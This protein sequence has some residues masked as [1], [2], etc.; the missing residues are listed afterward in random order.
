VDRDGASALFGGRDCAPFDGARAPTRPEIDDN[1][2][3]EDCNGSD[4]KSASLTAYAAGEPFSGALTPDRVEPYNLV[5]VVIEAARADHLDAFGYGKSTMP[6]F[7]HLAKESWLFSRAFSQSTATVLSVPSMMTG[8][9]PAAMHWERRGEHPQPAKSELLLAE[10]LQRRDYRTGFIVSSYIKKSFTGLQRGFQDLPL[11]EPDRQRKK[12]GQ[13]RDLYVTAQAAQFLA[14]MGADDHFFLVV[15]FPDP[16]APYIRHKDIDSARFGRGQIGNYDTELAFT[17]EQLRAL[18][19]ML[20]SRKSIWAH[21]ILVVTADHGEEFHEHGAERHANNCH[22]ETTHVPLLVRIPG[23]E[24]QRIDAPVGLVDILPTFLELI[25]E[26]EDLGRLT[27]RSLLWPALQP[28]ETDGER[29]LFCS[30]ASVTDKYGTF[31][32]RSLRQGNWAL[33]EDVNEGRF[34]LFDTTADPAEKNDL[35]AEAEHAELVQSL[36]ARLEQSL[37]GN[38]RDHTQM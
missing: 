4:G 8:T 5:W 25:G 37:V 7:S 27:G 32:R 21:T 10:R 31:F 13:R 23:M 19:E 26:N 22:V 12:D 20:R 35:A 29:P 16:H 18:V 3:D 36:R 9:D 38:L 14:R 6:Y 33:F 11:G 28:A 17:D 15:Y 34:S 30:I 2:V 1:G 24:P